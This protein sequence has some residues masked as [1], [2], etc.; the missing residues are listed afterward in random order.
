MYFVNVFVEK[1]LPNASVYETFCC[2]T[3]LLSGNATMR[4][5]V[6]EVAGTRI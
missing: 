1:C 4:M 2:C 5:T 6:T 3:T